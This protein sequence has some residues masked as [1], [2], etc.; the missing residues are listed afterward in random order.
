[1]VQ[2]FIPIVGHEVCLSPEEAV[3]AVGR[4]DR[5]VNNNGRPCLQRLAVLRRDAGLVQ[6]HAAGMAVRRLGG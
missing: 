4:E 1:M 6:I 5:G 3:L 2:P